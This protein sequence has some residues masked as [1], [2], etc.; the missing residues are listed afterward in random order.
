MVEFG[1]YHFFGDVDRASCEK[2]H[3]MIDEFRQTVFS[4]PILYNVLFNDG[5]AKE[6]RAES[7]MDLTDS[8]WHRSLVKVALGYVRHMIDLATKP[9]L[10]VPNTPLIDT[11]GISG[12]VQPANA[13]GLTESGIDAEIVEA[14][15]INWLKLHGL[16]GLVRSYEKALSITFDEYNLKLLLTRIDNVRGLFLSHDWKEEQAIQDRVK[17]TLGNS[18]YRQV[19]GALDDAYYHT[20]VR[21]EHDAGKIYEMLYK[22][23]AG[24]LFIPTEEDLKA[25]IVKDRTR[26]NK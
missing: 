18:E 23:H 6:N 24:K 20:A 26:K 13:P 8:I 14:L 16:S 12:L 4:D 15:Q 17:K 1:Q 7:F 22:N 21:L 3:L 10:I 19:F 5:Y 9:H 25:L 11:S 2:L